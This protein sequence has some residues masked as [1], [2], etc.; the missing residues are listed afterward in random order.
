MNL[1]RCGFIAQDVENA[2]NTY[3]YFQNLVGSST[4][5]RE[6]NGLE[7]D[8]KTLDYARLT[9]VLWGVLKKCCK[10][11]DNLEERMKAMETK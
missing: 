6:E 11:I 9:T 7:E 5:Q 4:I 8:I 3:E 2:V 10:K 1:K